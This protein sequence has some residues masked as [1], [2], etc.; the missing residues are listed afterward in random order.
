MKLT[1]FQRTSIER[2]LAI[3]KAA[4]ELR[5]QNP[6]LGQSQL[7]Q[8]F[9]LLT[10]LPLASPDVQKTFAECLITSAGLYYSCS[11]FEDG[12]I[13]LHEAYQYFEGLQDKY[14]MARTCNVYGVI[15][16]PLGNFAQALEY[17]LQ[18]LTLLEDT[19]K[20][21]YFH[22][23]VIGNLGLI[24]LEMGEYKEAEYYLQESLKYAEEIHNDVI[25][26]DVYDNLCKLYTYQKDYEHAREFGERALQCFINTE[27]VRGES[28]AYN[29]LGHVH[30]AQD[31]PQKAL[32]YHRRA[33]PLTQELAHRYEE[34]ESCRFI[35][36]ALCALD[37]V[38][39]AL[40]SI[41]AALIIA[42]ELEVPQLI[43]RSHREKANIYK[44]IG[45]FEAALKHHEL[46]YAVKEKVF[47]QDSERRVRTMALMEQLKD[48]Q[49][50]S[51]FL[52][53][54]NETLEK[55]INTR[56][57]LQ[58]QLEYIATIDPLTE[59]FNRRAFFHKIE[60][61]INEQGAAPIAAILLDVDNFKDVNDQ[62]G[63]LAGD[64]ALRKVG[65]LIQKAIR[66]DQLPC[67]FGGDEFAIF[68]PDTSLQQAKKFATQLHTQILD[69]IIEFKEMKIPFEVS[70]G[71]AIAENMDVEIDNLL[72]RADQALY[73]AKAAGKN[74]I[75]IYED[76][77]Y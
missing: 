29:S 27:H 25:A 16:Q 62:Y 66:N 65:E 22:I 11:E 2:A 36:R 44:K 69:T 38:Q 12:I 45:D 21:D 5:N 13:K 34:A 42:D 73:E 41:N 71:I 10:D 15:Y 75:K 14:G 35:A 64:L 48:A 31:D 58:S 60:S 53:Q 39:E 76:Q 23:V 8:A 33:L 72:D 43:Y 28:D 68:L 4:Y 17:Y 50:Q 3:N 51:E 20:T 56:K 6:E 1:E 49:E 40:I 70:L 26:G 24:Y 18:A 59:L 63:H 32:E 77:V 74:Q 67:R 52:Q 46:F 9:S 30:M 37:N 54:K 55:E 61:V 7:A 57:R 19:P 47:K